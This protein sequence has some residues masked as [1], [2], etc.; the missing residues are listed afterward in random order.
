[1]N[2][3]TDK[4]NFSLPVKPM[5]SAIKEA[6][7]DM[8]LSRS[9]EPLVLR[10]RWKSIN[11]R[12]LGGFRY[13]TL[14]LLAGASGH[15]K[16]YIL[17]MLHQDFCNPEL[18]GEMMEK[19]PYKILHFNFEMSSSD[20]VL[21]T[22]SGMEQISYGTLLSAE[23]QL[24]DEAYDRVRM[25]M[26]K[27]KSNQIYYVEKPGNRLEILETI[28]AFQNK[29]PDHRMVITLDH[30]LLVEYLDEKDEVKLLSELGKMFLQIRKD[31]GS[32]NILLGQLNDKIEDPRRLQIPSMQYPSK[33]DLHG[34]KQLYHACDS[35]MVI[36]RPE[37]LNLDFYGPNQYPTRDLMAFHL[38]K[39]RKGQPGFTRLK[40]DLA[41][42]RI[43]EWVDE[44]INHY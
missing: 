26:E 24:E 25:S 18:N 38:I 17:N 34:S 12:M 42:G 23:E 4:K 27:I 29:F 10:T 32:C 31:Y 3:N 43:V 22:V 40:S 14:N 30:T 9:G 21:R 8:D 28:R 44:Q 37:M 36:H 6:I 16:S 2:Q 5:A 13:S 19:Y 11:K 7:A 15:G 33:T 20:E 39:M 1:M 35:V 41:N